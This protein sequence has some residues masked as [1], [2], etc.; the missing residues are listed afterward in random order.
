MGATKHLFPLRLDGAVQT[1]SGETTWNGTTSLVDIDTAGT[2]A[3]DL[4][5]AELPGTLL[6][7]ER[8][9]SGS[10]SVTVKSPAD[11]AIVTLD[12]ATDTVCLIYT[13]SEWKTLANATA[14]G[15]VSTTNLSLSGSLAVGTTTT[16]TGAATLAAAVKLDVAS[17]ATVAEAT[18]RATGVT[19]NQVAGVVSTNAASLTNGTAA[20]LTVTNSVC[21]ANSVVIVV[22]GANFNDLGGSSIEVTPGSG[23]F[24]IEYKNV[25][26]GAVAT[27]QTFRFVV[28]NLV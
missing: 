6:T 9:A 5:D 12:S 14:S 16:L 8:S 7:I 2:Y 27:A 25:S 13:G 23:S 15:S 21:T 10:S 20:T 4:I 22:P 3:F 26:G 24:T 11:A 17:V 19:L 28:L 1:V 18:N